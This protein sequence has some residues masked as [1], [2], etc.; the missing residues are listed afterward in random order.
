M[1]LPKPSA[2]VVRSLNAAAAWFESSKIM[3]Y[4]W[5]GGRGTPGGRKLTAVEGA[6]PLW[7]RYYSLTTGKPIFGDR[8]KSIHDNVMEISDERP[9]GYGWYGAGPEKALEKYA[10][11]NKSRT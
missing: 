6:G 8:D 7:A 1:S 4:T 5:S 10:E 2:E 11:W 9:N 3:G